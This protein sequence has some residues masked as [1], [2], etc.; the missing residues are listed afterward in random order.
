[1]VGKKTNRTVNPKLRK[2]T[3]TPKEQDEQFY[4]IRIEFTD[5]GLGI[6]TDGNGFNPYEILGFLELVKSNILKSLEKK[7]G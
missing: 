3:T 5:K 2:L 7:N 1:M 4:S 6:S